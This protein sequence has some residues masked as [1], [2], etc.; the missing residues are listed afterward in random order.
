MVCFGPVAT[1]SG[2]PSEMRLQLIIAL[3]QCRDFNARYSAA[4]QAAPSIAVASAGGPISRP[5][6]SALTLAITPLGSTP[7]TSRV[8]Y[9]YLGSCKFSSKV[10]LM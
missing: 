2:S 1:H 7:W 3:S 10:V 9:V 5:T 6:P 4:L 8:V